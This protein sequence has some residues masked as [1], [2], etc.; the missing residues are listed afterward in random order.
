MPNENA[1]RQRMAQIVV[2]YLRHHKLLGDQLGTLISDVHQ[3]LGMLGKV[4][5]PEAARTPA[6]S[7]R[8]SVQPNAVV[9]LDCG[10]KGH[11]LRRHLTTRHGLS[12]E[13]YRACWNL[14]SEHLLIAPRIR[15]GDQH[16]RS[17]SDSGAVG[18]E[19]RPRKTPRQNRHR[20]GRV[21]AGSSGPA[22][23][24]H[25]NLARIIAPRI[26]WFYCWSVSP[27]CN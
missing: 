23:T 13:Q 1:G 6:I 5:E 9:C 10:W 27:Y 20:H 25:R 7:I 15:S 2:A 4:P 22:R 21:L 14:R 26:G 8:R 19:Q 18:A 24:P 3:T 11:M 17:R 12:P 16:W